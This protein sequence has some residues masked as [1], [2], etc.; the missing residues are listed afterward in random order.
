MTD[1]FTNGLLDVEQ[2][3]DKMLSALTPATT[4]SQHVPLEQA[5]GRILSEPVRSAFSVPPFDNSAMDGYALR[6]AD[7]KQSNTLRL[8]GKSFAVSLLMALSKPVRRCVL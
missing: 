3:M 1:C 5:C 6:S 8:I 2:A 7:L 4:E